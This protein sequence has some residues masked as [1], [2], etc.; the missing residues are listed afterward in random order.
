MFFL[1]RFL[2]IKYKIIETE[3]Y[4]IP[5]FFHTLIRNV[6]VVGEHAERKTKEKKNESKT[7]NVYREKRE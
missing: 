2:K 7:G 1:F 3:I 5:L 4:L 6:S